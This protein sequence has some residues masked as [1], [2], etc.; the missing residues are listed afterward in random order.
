[1]VQWLRL[2]LPMQGALVRSLV[3]ELRSQVPHGQKPK[4]EN[5]SNIVTNSTK[6]LGKKNNGP[7][8]K[9]FKKKFKG[10]NEEF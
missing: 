2:C 7:D 3:R 5:G 10:E 1:M 4:M 8:Q 9:I 6:T